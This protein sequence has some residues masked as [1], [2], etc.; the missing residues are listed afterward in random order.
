MAAFVLWDAGPW[1]SCTGSGLW[2]VRTSLRPAARLCRTRA[3]LSRALLRAGAS[4]RSRWLLRSGSLLRRGTRLCAGVRAEAAFA[5]ALRS[6]RDATTAMAGGYPRLPRGGTSSPRTSAVCEVAPLPNLCPPWQGVEWSAP[7]NCPISGDIRDRQPRSCAFGDALGRESGGSHRHGV[8][9]GGHAVLPGRAEQ[10]GLPGLP[11]GRDVRPE[12]GAGR[13]GLR[14]M[15]LAAAPCD[16]DGTFGSRRRAR[17]RARASTSRP[18]SSKPGLTAP[19]R[20]L[21]S[22]RP[23]RADDACR[24]C[25]RSRTIEDQKMKTLNFARAVAGGADRCRYR[26]RQARPH[27]PTSRTTSSNSSTRRSR[28]DPTRSSRSG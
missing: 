14:P 23:A 18:S 10:Q 22:A 27:W 24:P 12:D 26:L 5:R 2:R 1:L 17:R 16:P 9:V 4:L 11:A 28:Q 3:R 19:R 13:P 20:R 8:D 7:I 25:G 6:A 21:L 15:R